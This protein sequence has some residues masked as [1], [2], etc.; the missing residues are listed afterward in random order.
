MNTR[1]Y[2][3]VKAKRAAGAFD[4]EGARLAGGRWNSEGTAVVYTAGSR[5]LA[6]LEMLVHLPSALLKLNYVTIETQFDS[7][8]ARRVA[9]AE[10]PG[11]WR[12]DQPILATKLIGDKWVREA[13]SAVLIVPSVIVPE[14]FNY[15]LNPGHPDFKK[16][17]IGEP[18]DFSFDARLIKE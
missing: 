16:I 14:E 15:L 1:S 12:N 18:E 5:A 8:L 3:I 11:A 6:G 17:K 9:L 7:K 4:G 10:L 13:T 2:R